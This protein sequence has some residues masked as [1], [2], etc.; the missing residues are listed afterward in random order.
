MGWDEYSVASDSEGRLESGATIHPT[1]Y[2]VNKGY[3]A[4]YADMEFP[5]IAPYGMICGGRQIQPATGYAMEAKSNV[6]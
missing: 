3:A 1:A 2:T 5:E 4:S 6:Q